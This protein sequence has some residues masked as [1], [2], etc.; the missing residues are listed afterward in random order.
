MRGRRKK[1]RPCEKKFFSAI[2]QNEV[3]TLQPAALLFYQWVLDLDL[4]KGRKVAICR[5][6]FT[7]AMMDTERG[8]ARVMDARAFKSCHGGKVA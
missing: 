5:P 3:F 4:G 1:R 6:Q 2:G 7:H 8:N